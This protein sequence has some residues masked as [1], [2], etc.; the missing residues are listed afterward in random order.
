[1]RHYLKHSIALWALPGIFITGLVIVAR[2][3]GSLQLLEW[4]ALDSLL[5]LRPV[6]SKDERVVMIAITEQD[7]QEIG[8][9]PIPDRDLV[10]LIQRLQR[11]KP[12]AIALNILRELPS[13]PSTTT[14]LF[15]ALGHPQNV[16]VVEKALPE[17]IP[18]VPSFPAAQVGF[19]DIWVDGDSHLRRMILGTPDPI[20][21]NDLK[22]YKFSLAIRLAE[23]YLTP[24]GHPLKNGTRDPSAMQFGVT[25]LPRFLPNTGGYIRADSGGVQI[26]LNFRNGAHPFRTLSLAEIRAGNFEPEWLRD[27]IVVIGITDPRI[28][29]PIPTQ[30]IASSEGL[31]GKVHGLDIQAHAVSQILSAVLDQRPLLKSLADGWEYGFWICGWG[32]LAIVFCQGSNS[33]QRSL[34]HVSGACL[35]LIGV[36]YGFLLSGWWLP[37]VPPLMI[38][39]LTQIQYTILFSIR[40][41]DKREQDFKMQVKQSQRMLEER[42]R[43]IDERQRAIEQTFNVIHNGPL[44]TLANIL[45]HIQDGNHYSSEQLQLE[46][47]NLNY[48]IRSIGEHLKE[49]TLKQGNSLY[50]R[51]D[52]KLDLQVPIHSLF[53]EVYYS[54]L[55]RDFPGFSNLKLKV[56]SFDPIDEQYLNIE[57]KRWLCQFLEE[58]LCNV[59]KYAIG[60]TRLTVTGATHQDRYTLRIEDNG[61]GICSY[62]Y[63]GEGTRQANKLA[64]QLQ[65]EFKREPL[66][67]QGTLCELSWFLTQFS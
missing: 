65:G 30:A 12:A 47:N 56:R 31:S 53:Y 37:I 46:L 49:E 17:K 59:G 42:Q 63:T 19:S 66:A 24:K 34:L 9:Y 3:S 15:A 32:L 35:I 14:N 48:E 41:I 26:L 6:E 45:R 36:C 50:L 21:P 1:M 62:S 40:K 20:H 61:A 4:I 10:H 18:P 25:E 38:L 64:V 33:I 44:Q 5:R 22:Q 7:L 43:I 58:A 8:N 55:E 67:P 11:H 39:L 2:L 28:R 52:L 54:T 23:L 57:R 51:S 29:P 60:A 16:V 13:Q 27:R